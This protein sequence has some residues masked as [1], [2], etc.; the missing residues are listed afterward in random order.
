MQLRK[1]QKQRP[2]LLLGK[3]AGIHTRPSIPA[4]KGQVGFVKS[5]PWSSGQD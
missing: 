2:A 3:D 5:I 4:P 1:E